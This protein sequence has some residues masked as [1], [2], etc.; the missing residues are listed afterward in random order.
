[1]REKLPE[2]FQR[3]EF[4]LKHGQVDKI[5]DRRDMRAQISVI[6]QLLMKSSRSTGF[7]ADRL[8]R[9]CSLIP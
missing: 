1:M 7:D 9:R 2:G 6:T 8:Q 3:S 5:V 4:L